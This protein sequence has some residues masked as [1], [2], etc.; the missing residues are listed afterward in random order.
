[1]S[2]PKRKNAYK[3]FCRSARRV[4]MQEALSDP[5]KYPYAENLNEDG[6][7][8]AFHTYLDGYFFFETHWEGKIVYEVP[9]STMNPIYL[10]PK[11][12]EKDLFD[13]WKKNRT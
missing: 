11:D 3:V 13:M 2:I 5:D 10:D 6:D 1:M 7:V 8:L 9:T 12:A 4:T